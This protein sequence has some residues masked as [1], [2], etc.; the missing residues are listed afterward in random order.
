MSFKVVHKGWCWRLASVFFWT[1]SPNDIGPQNSEATFSLSPKNMF[2]DLVA[3]FQWFWDK[4][5]PA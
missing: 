2:K 5:T 1:R 3:R 4:R